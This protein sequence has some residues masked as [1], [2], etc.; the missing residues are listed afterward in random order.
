MSLA[1]A[2]YATFFALINKK[3]IIFAFLLG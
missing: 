3:G 1:K 2:Y